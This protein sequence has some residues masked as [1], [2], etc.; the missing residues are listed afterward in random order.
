[1]KAMFYIAETIESG[2]AFILANT[3][4]QQTTRV[5]FRN[6]SEKILVIC[7][8]MRIRGRKVDGVYLDPLFY[9]NPEWSLFEE[10]IN[11]LGV[12]PKKLIGN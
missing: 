6:G 4:W 10:R 2:V 9:L 5:S 1:M 8:F 3:D 11:Y 12:T 7:S